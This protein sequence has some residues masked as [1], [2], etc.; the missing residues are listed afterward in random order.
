MITSVEALREYLAP[1]VADP[2]RP[3]AV[4]TEADSLY[5][6]A[7]RLCLIQITDGDRHELI[8]LLEFDDLTPLRDYLQTAHVWMHGADY[9]ISMLRKNLGLAPP[10]VYDTQIAARLLGAKRFG[11]GNLV[12]DYLGVKL[13]KTSQKADW[14]KRPLTPTMTEYALNDVVYLFPLANLLVEKLKELG[15]YDWFVES[16]E[17][18]REK[19]LERVEDT[20][21][22]EAWRIN[23]SGKLNPLGLTYLR[24]LWKWRD[25]EAAEWDKP[26][27]MVISNKELLVW[28]NHLAAGERI[29]IPERYRSRRRKRLHAA[30]EAAREVPKDAQPQ[31]IVTKR[32]RLDDEFEERVSALQKVRNKNAE[33]LGID[34]S[35]IAPRAVLEAICRPDATEQ[36]PRELLLNWQLP[37]LG[38]DA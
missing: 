5:R 14:G 11:Y 3:C 24:E 33:A 10:V 28:V 34:P 27:F 6:Y 21:R 23:G 9:D 26:T 31:R 25:V 36:T 20:S 8:D 35:L 29:A 2:A 17:A 16:C 38:F 15:R 1:M 18:A 19:V 37:L 32:R 30:I 4:D 7:E 22:D 13:S 12:E